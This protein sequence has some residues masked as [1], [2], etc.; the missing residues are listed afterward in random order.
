MVNWHW[1]YFFGRQLENNTTTFIQTRLCALGNP[2]QLYYAS[3]II[4]MAL[5]IRTQG[6]Y[7]N[8]AFLSSDLPLI[9]WIRIFLIS[10][11]GPKAAIV[12]KISIAFWNMLIFE[13]EQFQGADFGCESISALII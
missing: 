1:H 4:I 5:I 3:G 2:A 10:L 9:L 11:G 13:E 6:V 8:L 12:S 7:S